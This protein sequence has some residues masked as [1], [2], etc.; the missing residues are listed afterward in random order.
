M[1]L[2][3]LRRG[4]D[5][6]RLY[7]GSDGYRIRSGGWY[8]GRTKQD[9]DGTWALVD[10]VVKLKLDGGGSLSTVVSK[11]QELDTLLR[12]SNEASNRSHAGVEKV[13]LQCQLDGEGQLRQSLVFNGTTKYNTG[14]FGPP[15]SR[16]HIMHDM[17]LALTRHPFWEDDNVT[18]HNYMSYT[19]S[20]G[21][22]Q[23]LAFDVYGDV[24]A[25]INS[26]YF[27]A[28]YPQSVA[29]AE[30]WVG[31]RSDALGDPDLFQPNWDCGDS[32]N[33]FGDGTSHVTGVNYVHN[34]QIARWNP[35]DSNMEERVTVQMKNITSNTSHQNGTF[36]VLLRARATGTSTFRARLLSGYYD[37]LTDSKWKTGSRVLIP[38]FGVSTG[39][40]LYYPMGFVNIPAERVET[41]T[42]LLQH[43]ALRLEVE[44]YT[45]GTGY[46]EMDT[47]TLIPVSE[48]GAHIKNAYIR[49][50][51]SSVW[52]AFIATSPDDES[53]AYNVV[54]AGSNTDGFRDIEFD[55]YHWG[56][57]T[58]DV[59][60]VCACQREY[61]QVYADH[62]SVDFQFYQ[63]WISLA[64]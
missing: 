36:L 41:Q 44:E 45:S 31:F 3:R 23:S 40:Y 64:S 35:G 59:A 33:D 32:D 12:R 17:D 37:E 9:P 62:F 56:M 46:L 53:V 49:N 19:S 61:E 4:S 48:G 11:V 50:Y 15:M 55:L 52:A 18:P 6:L 8:P 58:G 2:L 14:W 26:I 16:Q 25:R 10:E 22:M 1:T 21:G 27:N 42:S 5:Y 30:A 24:P 51:G 54:D 7:D 28:F 39:D 13:W 63:R 47:F 60:L 38:S 20:V 34:S 43:F 29:I 57:P